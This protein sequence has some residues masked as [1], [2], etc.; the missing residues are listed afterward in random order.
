M[1][2]IAR[3]LDISLKDLG[4]LNVRLKKALLKKTRHCVLA[5]Y[6]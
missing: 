1:Q 6:F 3:L 2:G 4:G 5:N